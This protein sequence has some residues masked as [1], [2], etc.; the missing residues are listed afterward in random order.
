M[1]IRWVKHKEGRR[2]ARRG[3]KIGDAEVHRRRKKAMEVLWAGSGGQGGE[4]WPGN[5][6]MRAE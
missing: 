2:G 5:V 3:R 6:E 4:M 1:Q